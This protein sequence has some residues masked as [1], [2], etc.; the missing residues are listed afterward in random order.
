MSVSVILVSHSALVAEGT[1]D[2]AAQMAADVRLI[3]AGG[4]ADGGIGTD[5]ALI[6]A[7]CESIGDGE[8]VIIADLGSAVMTAESVLELIDRPERFVIADAAFVEGAVAAAV[9]AQTGQGLAEVVAAAESSLRRTAGDDAQGKPTASA[10]ES[11][12][13]GPQ[14]TP[15]GA[16][17]TGSASD[18]SG[19]VHGEATLVNSEGL[20]ARPA[21][22]FVRLASTFDADVTINGVN[23]RS[24]L[25]IM[26]LG[27]VSG[28]TASIEATGPQAADAVDALCELISSGFGEA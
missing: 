27:L 15:T 18:S 4:R 21:A 11:A 1:R 20:H 12:A 2:I 22:D 17:S 14:P 16:A 13:V 24:L 5:Y 9:A 26:G 8:A 19:A 7:A 3:P 28:A 25:G 6:E 23:A 10:V